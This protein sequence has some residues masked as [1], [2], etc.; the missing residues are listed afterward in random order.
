M[1]AIDGFVNDKAAPSRKKVPLCGQA[2]SP[3]MC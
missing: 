1:T 3:D 2:I